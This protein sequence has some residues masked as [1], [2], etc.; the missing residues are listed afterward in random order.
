M[1]GTS[2]HTKDTAR[3][4]AGLKAAVHNPNVSSEAK[5]NALKRLEE[6]GQSADPITPA[7]TKAT[8]SAAAEAHEKNVL[9][10]Y[11]AATSNPHVSEE[12]KKHAREVLDAA[13]IQHELDTSHSEEEHQHRVLAGY[14][15]AIHNPNVSAAAKEH[16][17]EFLADSGVTDLD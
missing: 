16:A 14:K 6:M 9:R 15:A 5:E 2:E 11:K 8:Q 1:S 10:G 12:A 3:V 4:V 7:Q 17:R 13:G